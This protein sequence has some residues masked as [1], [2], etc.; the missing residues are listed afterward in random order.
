MREWLKRE[1]L[2]TSVPQNGTVG[3]NPTPIA[4]PKI[5]DLRKK[6]GKISEYSK[7][8]RGA[9]SQSEA[10]L[11]PKEREVRIVEKVSAENK[12]P[13]IS[14]EAPSFYYNP[15]KRYLSLV[16]AALLAGAAALLV[17]RHDTLT[18]IFLILSS[19]V[20]LLYSKQKPVISKIT[21]DQSGIWVDDVMY[22]YKDLKSFW[23]EYDPGGAKE[24]SLES[25]K[26]Y[27]PYVKILLNK[28]NPVE[29]RS[30]VINFLPE[31]EHENSL[32]DH[33]GRKLGL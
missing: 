32:V 2:K 28:Q 7:K 3:S 23:V 10:S 33:I 19:L 12:N 6:G 20:L 9:A 25:V 13:Q 14:W 31:K 15:Q 5:L 1:V 8:Q 29:I 11:T 18:S 27:M 30:L 24:L 17:F 16:I 21:V 22:P 4:M 26:W